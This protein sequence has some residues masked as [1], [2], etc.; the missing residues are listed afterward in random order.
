VPEKL[1]VVT[2]D[3]GY[4]ATNF[5]GKEKGELG[6]KVTRAAK[7]AYYAD[8]LT[9][10]DPQRELTCV[11]HLRHHGHDARRR[12]LLRW[13]NAEQ[14]N[15]GGR[16]VNSLGLDF[17]CDGPGAARGAMIGGTNKSCGTFIT[18]F[19]PGKFRPTPIKNTAPATR[20]HSATTRTPTR[21]G[22]RFEFTIRVR[23]RSRRSGRGR[24]S[25]SICRTASRRPAR[26]ST[27][28]A[29]ST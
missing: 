3:F 7:P 18:P 20:G 6:G 26:R 11:G 25:P 22:G 24:R 15:G 1:P 27:A 12:L 10:E 4:S 16:P 19:V 17:D 28:S 2:Q 5:A 23:A 8:K 13:F 21:A 14:E 9:C 29:C